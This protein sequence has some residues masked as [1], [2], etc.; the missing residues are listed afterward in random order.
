MGRALELGAPQGYVLLFLEEGAQVVP[1]LEAVTDQRMLPSGIRKYAR[2][3]LGAFGEAGYATTPQLRGRTD[4]LVEQLTPREI[5]VLTLIAA[6]HSNRAIA[7]TL[8]ITVRTV[9]KHTSNIYGKLN[10]NSRTQAA[11]YARQ[12]GL[13]PTDPVPE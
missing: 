10:V 8:V 11:A 12:I 4:E 1:L 6:G 13:L 5:E 3:L 2:K 7:E 9:K